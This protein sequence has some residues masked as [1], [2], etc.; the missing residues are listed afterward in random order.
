MLI[1]V[2]KRFVFVANTKAASTAIERALMP[3]AEIHRGG[4]PARKHVGLHEALAEYDFLFG[5]PDHPPES[6]FKFGV[7]RDPIDWITSWFRY[8]KGN[9]FERSLPAKMT[10][11]AFW[12]RGD[13]NIRRRGGRPNLQRDRF[14]AP[15]G[16][17]LADAIIPYHDLEAQL[18]TIFA[19]LGIEA[20]LP[21]SNVSRMTALPEEIP[22][23][24][25]A[26]M[27]E[28]YAEDYALFD[29]L[30]AINARGMAAL[31]ARG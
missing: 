10:F 28:F 5:Q 31:A 30:D 27:R 23:A 17:V 19:G 6:Y 26:E 16:T 9:K 24:L 25:H 11:A 4:T 22:A 7:M 12:A 1:G 18:G 2:R 14:T 15:D 8:R 3:H 29:R 13:W 20:A 21:R